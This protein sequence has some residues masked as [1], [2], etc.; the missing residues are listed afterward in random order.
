MMTKTGTLPENPPFHQTLKSALNSIVAAA[1]TAHDLESA[2]RKATRNKFL[3]LS[4][5][6]LNRAGARARRQE[7][8]TASSELAAELI[9]LP[10][11]PA[12]A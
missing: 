12:R 2:Y 5:N 3:R 7:P 11:E 6:E 4:P 9:H 1:K 10:D 8:R